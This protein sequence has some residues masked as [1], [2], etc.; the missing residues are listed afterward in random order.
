[1]GGL[2][3]RFAAGCGLLLLTLI[4]GCGEQADLRGLEPGPKSEVEAVISGNVLM[5]RE[6]PVRLAEIEVPRDSGTGASGT[7][8]FGTDTG[9]PAD[10]AKALLD[11]IATGQRVRLAFGGLRQRDDFTLAH[12]FVLR[13]GKPALWL[14]E[15]LV[16]AG[17]AQVRSWPDNRARAARLLRSEAEARTARRGLWGER[18]FLVLEAETL[19]SANIPRAPVRNFT[20]VEG[21]VTAAEE[22]KDRVYLNFGA[23][24]R[25]DFTASAA[26]RALALWPRGG[27]DLLALQGRRIRVRGTLYWR[28]G[29]A[30]ELTHPEQIEITDAG[31]EP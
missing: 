10:G 17:L 13:K 21:V 6:G 9:P 25:T 11:R 19:A 12:V 23:D 5:L 4:T 29:P 30:I 27:G 14:Q 8:D 1:M 26:S 31:A 18:R 7:G 3:R 22:R 2:I 15:E 24:W 28:N 20:L 16:R